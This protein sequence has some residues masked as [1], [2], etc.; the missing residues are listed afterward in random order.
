MSK[1]L[2]GKALANF[3]ANRDAEQEILGAVQ[4]IKA[5]LNERRL[6]PSRTLFVCGRRVG[7]RRRSLPRQWVI[8]A[9]V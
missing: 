8:E 1:K 6:E 7:S 5:W 2:T 9:Y 4:K 3:E